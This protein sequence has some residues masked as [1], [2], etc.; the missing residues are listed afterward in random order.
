MCIYEISD[1]PTLDGIEIE[2]TQD[3]SI[4]TVSRN[5]NMR[6]VSDRLP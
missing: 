2:F 6:I 1:Y 3:N 4:E 5:T